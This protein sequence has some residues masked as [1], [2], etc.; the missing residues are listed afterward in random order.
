[1]TDDRGGP[2]DDRPS[3]QNGRPGPEPPDFEDLV[4]RYGQRLF[5]LAYHLTGEK[6]IAEGLSQEVLVRACLDTRVEGVEHRGFDLCRELVGRWRLRLRGAWGPSPL[7]P[8]VRGGPESAALRP[9]DWLQDALGRLRPGER[10][11]LVLRVGEGFDYEEIASALGEPAGV[12]QRRLARARRHLRDAV[13]RTPGAPRL[14]PGPFAG[15]P[16]EA[17]RIERTMNLYLD[18]RLSRPGREEFERRL[19]QDA[20]L[21]EIVEL[22][23]G[24]TLELQEEAPPLP[25]NYADRA[26]LRLVRARADLESAAGGSRAEGAPAAAA[27]P[28]AARRRR[29]TLALGALAAAALV[30]AAIAALFG[31]R[32][33]RPP[34]PDAGPGDGIGVGGRAGEPDEQTLEALR[35]LGYIGSGEAGRRATPAPRPRARPSPSPARRPSSGTSPAPRSAG[36]ARTPPAAS[37][38]PATPRTAP[39]ATTATPVPT[40]AAVPAPTAAPARTAA[41]VPAPAPAPVPSPEPAQPIVAGVSPAP[42]PSPVPGPSPGAAADVA[43]APASFGEAIAHRRHAAPRAPEPGRDHEIIRTPEAWTALFSG[44]AVPPVAFETEW[45]VVL[46]D[47]LGVDPPSR[48]RVAAVGR[49]AGAIVIECRAEP[50]DP[51]AASGPPSPGQ[52]VVLPRPEAPVRIQ[53]R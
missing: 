35:S 47:D 38:G 49:A 30:A 10:E 6:D 5:I 12:V 19:A 42:A 13:L 8:V 44:G 45:V 50:L 2:R 27:G 41:P 15:P 20:R 36:A 32:A 24:L 31:S 43:P 25:R 16:G 21:R 3:V 26:H 7:P 33:E 29:A 14:T 40:P 11:V 51:S 28:P 18:D 34:G 9:R 52:A 22:H 23:R 1:M 53:V 17:L 39:A 4:E 48:L 46:R 37:R